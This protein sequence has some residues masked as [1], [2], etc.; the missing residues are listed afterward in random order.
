MIMAALTDPERRRAAGELPF[1]TNCHAVASS[2]N[3]AYESLYDTREFA[4]CIVAWL[5][6]A[7]SP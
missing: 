6:E 2:W 4:D 7:V 3:A 5:E 1:L